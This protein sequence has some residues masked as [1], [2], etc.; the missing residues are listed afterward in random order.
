MSTAPAPGQ[1]PQPEKKIGRHVAIWRNAK[2][3]RSVT[4]SYPRYRDP[5][6]GQWCDGRFFREGDIALLAYHLFKALEYLHETSSSSLDAE[7]AA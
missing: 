7:E 2:G 5:E 3:L 4:V 6:S 1:K